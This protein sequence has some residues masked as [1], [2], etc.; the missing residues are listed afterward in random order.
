MADYWR[1]LGEAIRRWPIYAGFVLLSLLG[2]I[3]SGLLGY[4]LLGDDNESSADE[5]VG[6]PRTGGH[7][8]AVRFYHK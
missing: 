2:F 4:R 7:G 5:L 3:S 6:P 8:G 1:N